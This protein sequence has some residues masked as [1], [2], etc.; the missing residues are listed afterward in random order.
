MFAVD[1]LLAVGCARPS[2]MMKITP[3]S[4]RERNGRNGMFEDQLLLRPGFQNYRILVKAFD[5][6]RKLNSAHQVNRYIASFLTGT[7]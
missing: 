4:T 7:V 5:S 1:M 6:P 2:T 3:A